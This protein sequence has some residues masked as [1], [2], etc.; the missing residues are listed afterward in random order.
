MK[1]LQINAVYGIGSTGKNVEEMHNYLKQHKIDSYVGYAIKSSVVDDEK[2]FKI[3]NYLDYKFHALMSRIIGKQGY[4]SKSTTRRFL[5]KIDFISPDIVH[6]HNLHSNFINLPYLFDYLIKNNIKTVITLHDCWFFTGKCC[7]FSEENCYSWKEEC[8]NCPLLNKYNKSLFFDFSRGMYNDRKKWYSELDL[9]VIGVSNWITECARESILKDSNKIERIYNWVDTEIYYPKKSINIKK[10]YNL[11]DR[12]I[13]LAV[14]QGWAEDKG[15]S[16][17]IILAEVFSNC[18]LVLV[19]K[20]DHNIILPPNIIS[21]DYLSNP[22]DLAELYSLATVFIN[23][24]RMETFGKVTIEAMACGTPVVVYDNTGCKE[25]VTNE[26]GFVCK[27]KDINDMIKKINLILESGKEM[28]LAECVKSVNERFTKEK[29][30]A[31]YLSFYKDMIKN[32]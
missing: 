24:S 1:I 9:G 19:G 18:Q 22:H 5:K 21:I 6:L 10:K 25:L 2:I 3:G 4:F 7:H 16:D 8:G 28:Y 23:P 12:D 14:S 17:I 11:D 15:L 13:L 31:M 26:T 30:L 20:L 27:N 29:N 32:G